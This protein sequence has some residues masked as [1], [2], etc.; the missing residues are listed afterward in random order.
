M[1]TV[2][3]IESLLQRYVINNVINIMHFIIKRAGA[4]TRLSG[5]NAQ[6]IC[7][8]LMWYAKKVNKNQRKP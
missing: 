8:G 6:K 5:E 4:K 3:G 7:T 2:H 1:Y